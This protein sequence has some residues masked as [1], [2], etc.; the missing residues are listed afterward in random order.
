MKTVSRRVANTR[1]HWIIACDA[2]MEPMHFR[3]GEWF[4]EAK[5]HMKA[6]AGGVTMYRAE[7]AGEKWCRIRLQATQT[8]EVRS[9]AGQKRTNGIRNRKMPSK[10]PRAS[11]GHVVLSSFIIALAERKM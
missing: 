8:C 4:S 9:H 10:L 6:L 3:L 7:G 2:N 5:A 1:S 11:K